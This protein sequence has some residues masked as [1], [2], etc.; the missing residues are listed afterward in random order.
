MGDIW[1]YF[2]LAF[3]PSH[4]AQGVLVAY[5]LKLTAGSYV[6]YLF[7]RRNHVSENS[8][9]YMALLYNCS[10]WAV[11]IFS[12]VNHTN[13]LLYAPLFL[14]I[15]ENILEHKK[16]ARIA[17]SFLMAISLMNSLVYTFN[18]TV[19]VFIYM[20]VKRLTE[21]KNA[22]KL[23]GVLFGALEWIYINILAV[24]LGS[25]IVIPQL[26]LTLSST[27]SVMHGM[28]D[29]FRY[30]MET[31]M[32]MLSPQYA[33]VYGFRIVWGMQISSF[34]SYL[35]IPLI[36]YG[37]L[38]SKRLWAQAQWRVPLITMGVF[39]ILLYVEPLTVALNMFAGTYQRWTLMIVIFEL[40]LAGHAMDVLNE[41][42]GDVKIVV[43]ITSTLTIFGFLVFFYLA[44]RSLNVIYG[45]S[46]QFLSLIFAA[47]LVSVFLVMKKN[48]KILKTL[49]VINLVF[50]YAV[51]AYYQYQCAS[52]NQFSTE[53]TDKNVS[54]WLSNRGVLYGGQAQLY[55]NSFIT[56]SVASRTTSLVY[57]LSLE[58]LRLMGKT[59]SLAMARD[60]SEGMKYLLG[61][62]YNE[63]LSFNGGENCR[64]VY[65]CLYPT[66]YSGTKGLV[67][68]KT[69]SI[70]IEDFKKLNIMDKYRTMMNLLIGDVT[71][72]IYVTKPGVDQS[73]FWT[74]EGKWYTHTFEP[75][76]KNYVFHAIT[77]VLFCINRVGDTCELTIE[78]TYFDANID[79]L[80][81][82]SLES[83]YA[84]SWM[85]GISR[86][87]PNIN[88][89][90]AEALNIENPTVGYE[91]INSNRLVIHL[92]NVTS[93]NIVMLPIAYD[94]SFKIVG[95]TSAYLK[96]VQLGM[97]GIDGLNGDEDI[98]IEYRP[99]YLK[100]IPI[101]YGLAA[102]MLL[103]QFILSKK[104]NS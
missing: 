54:S 7:L 100:V 74:K 72:G 90:E 36:V 11:A 101:A 15:A 44:P 37:L 43:Y 98:I 102:V 32:N 63:R 93:Q 59:T 39:L 77:P 8:S 12:Y 94:S 82:L 71:T 45:D 81:S 103:V 23:K 48:P 79:G 67:F 30:A 95:T 34:A 83:A 78:S 33:V 86:I 65:Y 64:D 80:K 28:S 49:C 66:G 58:E 84:P 73:A 14:L 20:T 27:R 41:N 62:E 96:D 19:L 31:T 21:S 22:L 99:P 56:R 75:T 47:T 87:E 76:S 85:E 29:V 68:D 55:Y 60:Y 91:W 40:L 70:S 104:E 61:A 52:P 26:I 69:K 18:F 5:I 2:I 89:F 13:Y 4:I 88:V 51:L 25:V 92:K 1:T 35:V 3:G 97:M 42:L 10:F 16:Y 9:F 6:T 17:M 57:S 46:E 53:Y 50:S 38:K 24:L